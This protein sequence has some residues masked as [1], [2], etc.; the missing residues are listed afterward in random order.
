[1]SVKLTA[2]N[3]WRSADWAGDVSGCER[4][5]DPSVP[6]TRM[7]MDRFERFTPDRI[8]V[9]YREAARGGESP[10]T[11]TLSF[12]DRAKSFTWDAAH[13]LPPRLPAAVVPF[14][15]QCVGE[16]VGLWP[17]SPWGTVK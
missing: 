11:A 17:P 2:R 13:D 12:G 4:L 14:V 5:I 7:G 8:R 6:V 16:I 3:E 1:M 10:W 9:R 15:Q